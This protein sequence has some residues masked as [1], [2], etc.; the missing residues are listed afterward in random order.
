M[1]G[2]TMGTLVA[3]YFIGWAAVSA[4]VGRLTML[5]RRLTRRQHDLQT[6]EGEQALANAR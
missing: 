4:Y 3:A 1:K 2:T 5:S 6:R